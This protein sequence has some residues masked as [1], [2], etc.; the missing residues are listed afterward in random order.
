LPSRAFGAP[1]RTGLVGFTLVLAVG[2][3]ASASFARS[4]E[5][6]ALTVYTVPT[7]V[8][9]INTADDRARGA[10]NNP[11]DAATNKLKP[12]GAETGNG[13]YPG[14]VAVYSF[15]LF[16]GP[17]LTKRA[18]SASYTCYFN[19]ARHALCQAYYQL[20]GGRGTLVASGPT[21][22]NN[23][24]FT[25][26]LTGGTEQYLAAR[27]QVMAVAATRN[28]QRV[29]FQLLGAS[30]AAS[31]ETSDRKSLSVYAVPATAQFMN[32]ADD[33]LRGMSAN[34][35][36]VRTQALVILTKGKEKRNGPFPGD[37][38]LYSF[39]L[40]GDPKLVTRAGSAMFTCYYTFVKRAV[41]DSYLEL[42]DGVVLA[43]GRVV[44]NA[45]RFA[46]S[47]TGGTGKYLGTLGEVI[48]TPAKEQAERLDLQLGGA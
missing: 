7:G 43:S 37:D 2:Q 45:T 44:F 30:A 29:R 19:Y 27:G 36:N 26:V 34:P 18:G 31:H 20:S 8:Q 32:H 39:K 4:D 40:Y 21:D 23:T 3:A 9:F 42:P 1:L 16:A 12:G 13:P 15:D 41:C 24:G 11:F 14:D 46:L 35:F 25:L 10:G 5:S 33:R 22:F 6:R 28:S 48:A 17:T 38:I 47:V